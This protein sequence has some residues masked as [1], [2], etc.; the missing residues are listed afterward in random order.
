MTRQADVE[1]R[2]IKKN[3]PYFIL[4]VFRVRQRPGYTNQP[5]T[6]EGEPILKPPSFCDRPKKT[7]HPT[8]NLA[9]G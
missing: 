3:W 8:K 1:K 2:G 9:E 5:S 6:A 4:I 7:V